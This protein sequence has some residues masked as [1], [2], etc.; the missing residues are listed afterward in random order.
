MKKFFVMVAAL[1]LVLGLAVNSYAEEKKATA[2][3][4]GKPTAAKAMKPREDGWAG[5]GGG[6]YKVMIGDQVVGLVSS[7]GFTWDP[8]TTVVTD[9]DNYEDIRIKIDWDQISP[10]VVA[11]GIEVKMM[12]G[13]E[14]EA[15]WDCH[16]QTLDFGEG[17]K[18]AN[19]LQLQDV[20]GRQ[21]KLWDCH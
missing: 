19:G 5:R 10:D 15:I 6:R 12:G 9:E 16:L 18:A 17:F 7:A 8:R 13:Q 1:G 20:T 11:K 4:A 14:G 3:G 2:K 21:Y